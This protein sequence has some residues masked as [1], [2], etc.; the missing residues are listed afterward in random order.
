[1]R[2]ISLLTFWMI[3]CL[4]LTVACEKKATRSVSQSTPPTVD[5][6]SGD[7]TG[8]ECQANT[9]LLLSGNQQEPID[10]GVLPALEPDFIDIEHVNSANEVI[11][12]TF[13][14]G[15]DAPSSE[16]NLAYYPN[17]GQIE[18]YEPDPEAENGKRLITLQT[19]SYSNEVVPHINFYDQTVSKVDFGV[20]S[21]VNPDRQTTDEQCGKKTIKPK[22]L[23]HIDKNNKQVVDLHEVLRQRMFTE[24]EMQELCKNFNPIAV[25]FLKNVPQET[26]PNNAMIR[27]T[28]DMAALDRSSFMAL[29]SSNLLDEVYSARQEQGGDSAGL[30]LSNTEC[31]GVG[32]GSGTGTD[33]TGTGNGG[34]TLS[35]RKSD[36][37]ARENYVWNDSTEQCDFENP[38]PDYAQLKTECEEKSDEGFAWDDENN[39]CV[40]TVT[41]TEDVAGEAEC[42]KEQGS[43]DSDKNSCIIKLTQ[44]S[45]F[46]SKKT[47]FKSSNAEGKCIQVGES[48]AIT[49][50]SCSTGKE[51]Q[52]FVL[53]NTDDN[54]VLIKN[55]D[56][57]GDSDTT[58]CIK[59]GDKAEDAYPLETA[60]CPDEPSAEYKFELVDIKYD[61]D[62]T[63]YK[64]FKSVT[65]DE[66]GNYYCIN[67]A[68]ESDAV[69]SAEVCLDIAE[70]ETKKPQLFKLEIYEEKPAG[71][72]PEFSDFP[73]ISRQSSIAA[74]GGSKPGEQCIEVNNDSNALGIVNCDTKS[75]NQLFI[76]RDGGLQTSIK[77]TSDDED[78]E[79]SASSQVCIEY[80]DDGV[81]AAD[82]D[83]D[84]VNQQLN[85]L[86]IK[87]NFEEGEKAKEFQLIRKND[88][89][90]T[91]CLTVVES[92]KLE[93]NDCKFT[94]EG[95]A[96]TTFYKDLKSQL[97][98]VVE[99]GG[100]KPE[101]EECSIALSL[102]H[103]LAQV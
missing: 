101:E 11:L 9:A 70:K 31:N 30:F 56:T 4:G 7:G 100:S 96:P 44:V 27:A 103:P 93:F 16:T 25:D 75:D 55:T 49:S 5:G 15:F 29:C 2:H 62:S 92:T 20:R 80:T 73:D 60:S 24:I 52:L 94:T 23:P 89:T 1:M 74:E 102:T 86:S 22:K 12:E 47:A 98:T 33:S 19:S 48:N 13:V 64:T 43:W 54:K 76:S 87:V 90:S 57:S 99:G 53:E 97:F 26:H 82:C 84:K 21:C 78:D 8:D 65:K 46:D 95:G 85:M 38:G 3:A 41:T 71:P 81:K 34:K 66:Q 51:A 14:L 28:A 42:I 35:E 67:K 36:C 88:G 63:T 6:N 83:K 40:Q 39:F 69:P 77:D 37:E 32:G 17:F 61:D 50:A 91:E 72:E 79:K 18:W 10:A 59:L 45:S 68:D 58:V